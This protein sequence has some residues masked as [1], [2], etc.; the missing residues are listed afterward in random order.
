M[1]GDSSTS[2][3]FLSSAAG[4][5]DIITVNGILGQSVTFPLNIQKPQEVENI[6]WSTPE[7]SVAFVK[8][9]LVTEVPEVSVTHQSFRGRI[10]VSEKNFDLVISLLKKQ[11]S[12]IYRADI[13][14]KNKSTK[15][16][17]F[18]LHVYSES[19]RASI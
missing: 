2:D 9:N 4:S 10:N 1:D 13:N 16:Q 5:E 11:D 19:G 3:I 12:R 8:P 15:S 17:R 18:S 14:S 7:M 6:A